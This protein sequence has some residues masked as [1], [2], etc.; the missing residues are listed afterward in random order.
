VAEL[1]SKTEFGCELCGRRLLCCGESCRGK[2]SKDKQKE[3]KTMRQGGL[4]GEADR[5]RT[6]RLY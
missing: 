3:K 4:D 1:E 5:L 6:L 2:T